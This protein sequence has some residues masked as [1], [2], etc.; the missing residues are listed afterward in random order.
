MADPIEILR[1]DTGRPYIQLDGERVY[2]DA[3]T[4]GSDNTAIGFHAM[5]DETVY[6][7]EGE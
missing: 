5:D 7:A 6:V 3:I 2:L 1:D 4:T